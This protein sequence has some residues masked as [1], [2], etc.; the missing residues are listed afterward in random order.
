MKKGMKLHS[1]LQ[2]RTI[3]S[4]WLR[5]RR[6]FLPDDANWPRTGLTDLLHPI[7]KGLSPAPI[8]CLAVGEMGTAT[9][10]RPIVVVYNTMPS[11]D[12]MAIALNSNWHTQDLSAA[13]A[14]CRRQPFLRLP[15]FPLCRALSAID[16]F[17]PAYQAFI[18]LDRDERVPS[19]R[20]IRSGVRS[21]DS[22]S[23][24]AWR[25]AG[26]LLRQQQAAAAR[27]P[28]V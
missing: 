8:A 25:A 22:P 21:S 2:F 28:G 27:R 5:L 1:K 13:A 12:S 19:R 16:A 10:M 26:M 6:H 18:L 9:Y 3:K 7:A 23:R 14:S 20:T 17:G 15:L 4:S 11:G 24:L